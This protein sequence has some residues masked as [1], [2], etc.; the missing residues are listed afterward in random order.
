MAAAFSA[1]MSG[2]MPG[3]PGGDPG[4]VAEA[5]GGQAQQR[6]VL[7]GA[8]G[9]G[10]HQRGRHEVR[11]VRHHGDEAVVVGRREDEHVGAQ[12][13]HDALEPVEGLQV[14]GRRRGEHPH[15]ADEEVGV[16]PVQ[17]RS[18]R[19]RPWGGRR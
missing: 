15:R 11:H 17:A 8:V 18:A 3:M 2:Q 12:A 14:G 9:R 16:G 6:A 7:L 1:Q 13:H 5:A 4:H 10:V 19:S